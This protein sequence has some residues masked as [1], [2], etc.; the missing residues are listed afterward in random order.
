M[1]IEE[2][3]Q[4]LDMPKGPDASEVQVRS[5]WLLVPLAGGRRKSGP[6]MVEQ[7]KRHRVRLWE[8]LLQGV[9]R[10]LMLLP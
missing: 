9:S 1:S 6:H 2:A 7:R 5:E 8:A 3:L 10:P 4:V